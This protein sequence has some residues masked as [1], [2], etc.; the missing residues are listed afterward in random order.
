MTILQ[1][2]TWQR[3]MVGAIGVALAGGL[4]VGGVDDGGWILPAAL[5]GS[6]LVLAGTW[7]NDRMRVEL[8][9]EV[10]VVNF[11]RTLVLPW[12]EVARFGY[13][14]EAWVRRRDGRQYGI[15]VFS[16]A[17]GTLPFVERSCRQAVATME[18]HRKRRR[19]R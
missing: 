4:V 14:G 10:V 7:R 3:L 5:V 17:A 1:P 12:A 19:R 16:P 6:V 15:T 2:P 18:A 13:D 8:G 11:L 9:R